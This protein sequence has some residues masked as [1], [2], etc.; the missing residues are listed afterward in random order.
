MYLEFKMTL[1][2]IR[3]APRPAIMIM[4]MPRMPAYELQLQYV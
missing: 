4:I 1:I 2:M 3:P